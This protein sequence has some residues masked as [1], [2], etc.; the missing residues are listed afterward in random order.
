MAE[1]PSVKVEPK[2]IVSDELAPGNFAV[3]KDMLKERAL[4]VIGLLKDKDE[5]GDDIFR[6][7]VLTIVN[8]SIVYGELRDLVMAES[9]AI[10]DATQW[11]DRVYYE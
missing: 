11:I 7:I 8:G 1:K 5:A 4:Q 6:N 3:I 10:N 2:S 9:D